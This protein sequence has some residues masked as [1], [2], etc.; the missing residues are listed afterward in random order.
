MGEITTITLLK[1]NGFQNK[2]WALSMMQ[3]AKSYLT[4]IEGLRFYKLLG[5][6]KDGFKPQP[7]WSTYALL[8]VWANEESANAFFESSDLIKKY[9]KHS[10]QLCK[11][12]LKSI[13]AHGLWSNQ[14]PFIKS[15]T[16]STRPKAIA[17][18]TRASIKTSELKRFWKYVPHTQTA[19]EKAKGL[20]Y[21]KGFGE[22][23]IW[24]MATLSIWDSLD[25]AK[26]YAYSSQEHAQAV[27]MT[28]QYNWYKEELF[29]RFEVYKID[30]E[31]DGLEGMQI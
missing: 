6:G 7:D 2:F 5:S 24:E 8:Q 31:W 11:L 14:K 28:R 19:I 17:I 15:K 10:I 12:Y 26:A 27:K 25:S 9:N 13:A 29:S 3:F 21:T 18:I 20:L 22:F 4:G 16:L 23:P 1:Y 30:G